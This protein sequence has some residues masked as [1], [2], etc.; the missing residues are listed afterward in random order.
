MT[1]VSTVAIVAVSAL[2]SADQAGGN[3]VETTAPRDVR[4]DPRTPT[5]SGTH[6]QL[7]APYTGGR[8]LAEVVGEAPGV[9]V[10]HTAFGQPAFATIRGSNPRQVHVEWEGLRLNPPFGPGYDLGGTSMLGFD[11]VIVWRGAAATYRGT[12]AVSGV[13]EFRTK[14]LRRPGILIRTAGLGGSFGTR[15]ASVDVD[16][17]DDR[18]S[19][20]VGIAARKSL[21]DFEFVDAQGDSAIRTNND[22]ERVGAFA[23]SELRRQKTTF[24]ATALVDGGERGTPGQSEFQSQFSRARLSDRHVLGLARV[25]RTDLID[26]LGAWAFDG[27]GVAGLQYRDVEYENPDPFFGGEP[28]HNDADATTLSARLG[29]TAWGPTSVARVE[30]SVRRE[31]WDDATVEARRA[32]AGIGAGW[33]QRFGERVVLFG[34]GRFEAD[35]ERQRALLPSLGAKWTPTDH[36]ELRTNGGLTYRTPALD[37]LYLD[38]E[39]LRGN[40]QLSPERAWVADLTAALDRG[41]GGLSLTGFVHRTDSAIVFLPVTAYLVEATNIE[42][43][44]AAGAEAA[45]HLALGRLSLRG[46]YTFTE[47]RFLD[48]GEPV[49]LQPQHQAF[50]RVGID[51]AGFDV[52]LLRLPRMLELWTLADGRS[53]LFLDS[54]GNQTAPAYLFWDAGIT[55]RAGAVETTFAARNLMDHRRAV[56]AV[57]QPLPGRSFWLSALVRWEE[58]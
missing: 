55:L 8:D 6:I 20:R 10:R 4:D 58:P 1:A 34:S 36:V 14:H 7:D 24:R 23:S 12:G 35:S 25:E 38:T 19:N 27:F 57:Q 13:L 11:E 43:T 51:V 44:L 45:A 52:P 3:R 5:A 31:T 21:G 47:A 53:R 40:P 49:P 16:V 26:P 2:A 17:A 46:S 39:T 29:G 22:H 48:S 30:T 37:E 54:F 42:G 50:G 9:H 32:T 18:A 33:E 56:D 41:P 15:A 28:I